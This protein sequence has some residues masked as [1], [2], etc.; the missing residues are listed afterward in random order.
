MKLQGVFPPIPTP[1]HKGELNLPGLRTNVERWMRTSVAGL[2][3]L[4]SNG[5]APLL[6]EEEADAVVA[7][8]RA[9]LLVGSAPTFFPSL[10]VGAVVVCSRSP[11]SYRTYA[12]DCMRS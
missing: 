8:V 2:V 10:C 9:G 3:V 4:G 11:A 12:R 7:A 1:F 5:E 6:D